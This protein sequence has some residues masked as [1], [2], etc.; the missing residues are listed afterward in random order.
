[1]QLATAAKY[2]GASIATTGTGGAAIGIAT[3]FVATINGTS[4]NPSLRSTLFPQAIT[5]FATS[6]ACGTF[7]TMISFT[8]TY[9]V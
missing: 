3:V 2:I 9:A 4:R 7:C 1:M 6:E 8:T 5:G